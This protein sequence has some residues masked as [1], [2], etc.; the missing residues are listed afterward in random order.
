MINYIKESFKL[1]NKYIILATPLIFFSLL[2]SLY[3][4]F[5]IGGNIISLII[6]FVLFTLM[7]AAFLSGWGHMIKLCIQDSEKDDTN[8]IIKEFPAGVGEYF[9]PTL[10]LLINIL[11]FSMIVLFITYILGMKFIGDLGISASAMSGA[12]ESTATLK[13]FLLSLSEEQLYRLNAWNLLLFVGMGIEYFIVLFYI[14]ALFYK[15]KNPYKSFFYALKDLF[16]R[17]FLYNALLYILL[18]VSYF[19]LSILTTIF[20]INPITHF[21]FTLIN[22]YYLVFIT[23][24]LFKYYY[25]NFIR[26]GG[27]LD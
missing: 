11:I 24:L 22:F 12:F 17:K 14:P 7:L 20:G 16:S 3:I 9:L 10:G 6:A 2:S 25:E 27:K 19:I 18:F 5:S 21:I 4:L 23:V 1:T 26:V 8:A 13:S 15:T